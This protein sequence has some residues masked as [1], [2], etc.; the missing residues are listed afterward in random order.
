MSRPRRR[1]VHKHGDSRRYDDWLDK[2]GEDVVAAWLLVNNDLCYNAAAFH[3]QQ[4]VEKALKAYILIKSAALVDG[5]NLPWL[6]KKAMRYHPV[7]RNW[8]DECTALS[9][10]Y[11]ETRYPADLPLELDFA[12]VMRHYRMAKDMYLFICEQVDNMLEE[13]SAHPAQKSK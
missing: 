10:C 11:I 9:H 4:A 8:M 1:S 12:R 5:H 7:F 3:C 13:N 6:C 2:A